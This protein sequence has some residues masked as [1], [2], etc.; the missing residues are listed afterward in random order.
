[1][2]N[3][4]RFSTTKQNKTFKKGNFYIA[5]SK[6][7]VGPTS[8]SGFYNG[9]TP[10]TGG[11][12]IY[13]NKASQGPSIRIANN[14]AELIIITN[15]IAK[16]NYTTVNQCFTYFSTQTEK[17]IL[18]RD[19]EGIITDGLVLNL[20]AGYLPSY[21]R[22]G[23]TWY[24]L[25]GEGNNA[26]IYNGLTFNSGGWMEF[27]GVD[28][29]CSIPYNS[30]TMDLWKTG[31]TISVWA[32]H[33]F[34]SGRRNIWNQAYGGYGTWTHESGN[35]INYYY[36]NAGSNTTP[37]T[38]RN[39]GTTNRSV[40]NHLTITRDLTT[41]SWYVNGVLTSSGSN[42]YGTLKTTAQQVLIGNGY[43]GYWQGRM[44]IIQSYNRAL[45]A[46]EVLSNFNAQKG[47]F[48]L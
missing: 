3:P 9:I 14:D 26:T 17:S 19:Y 41:V 46:T 44:S 33:T 36:G 28:D 18:N 12:T 4:V 40:W 34:T 2:P 39:S 20:D 48:G 31:Q 23:N 42:P 7:P 1:M 25:S 6:D 5:S 32:Y 22:I 38:S 35:N 10:P 29:Y 21:P 27:D 30:S 13:E 47:R 24:D 16:T 37:Y 8:S 43:A 45:T 15:Q 11:Y